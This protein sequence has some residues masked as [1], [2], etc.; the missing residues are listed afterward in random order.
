MFFSELNWL[1]MRMLFFEDLKILEFKFQ[2][3]YLHNIIH[4]WLIYNYLPTSSLISS[5]KIR[6]FLICNFL[7][8]LHSISFIVIGQLFS[9]NCWCLWLMGNERLPK[10][11]FAVGCGYAI[12]GC[13]S[14]RLVITKSR[15]RLPQ[16]HSL[17]FI[18]NA[19]NF[20]PVSNL[21]FSIV[22]A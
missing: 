1:E 16:I 12:C 6:Y 18:S 2:F 8:N 22:V 11:R 17:S 14:I 20:Q 3:W 5:F 4:A 13:G 19:L 21:R 7:F 15:L 9:D 10:L